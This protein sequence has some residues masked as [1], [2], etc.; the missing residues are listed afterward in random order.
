MKE[1]DKIRLERLRKEY[2]QLT[3]DSYFESKPNWNG[4]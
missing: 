3:K 4:F 1:K 2:Y